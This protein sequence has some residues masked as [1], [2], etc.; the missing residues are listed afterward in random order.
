M[1]TFPYESWE[2][3][4]QAAQELGEGFFTFGPGGNTATVI[5]TILGAIVMVVTV[6]GG[7]VLEDRNLEEHVKRIKDEGMI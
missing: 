2:E 4:A 5:L 7:V 6:F 3:A 1:D